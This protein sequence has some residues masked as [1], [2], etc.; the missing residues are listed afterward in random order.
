[1]YG[2]IW[3]KALSA[4]LIFGVDIAVHLCFLNDFNLQQLAT[5]SIARLMSLSTQLKQVSWWLARDD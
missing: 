3:T 4:P 1:M 5:K 2:A